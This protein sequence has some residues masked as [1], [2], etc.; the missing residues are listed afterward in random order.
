MGGSTETDNHRLLRTHLCRPRVFQTQQRRT[1]KKFPFVGRTQEK[2]TKIRERLL[3]KSIN[4]VSL[5]VCM[6]EVICATDTTLQGLELN[7]GGEQAL[8]GAGRKVSDSWERKRPFRPILPAS[9]TSSI[10]TIP[11]TGSIIRVLPA[12]HTPVMTFH[13][14]KNPTPSL[15]FPC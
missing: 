7:L 1:P 13:L 9:L 2:E 11:T 6:W 3:R 10:E 15:A 4:L 14:S 5:P 8:S 12:L